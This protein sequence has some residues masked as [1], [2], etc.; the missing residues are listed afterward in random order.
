MNRTGSLQT[1]RVA[2]TLVLTMSLVMASPLTRAQDEETGTGGGS[3]TGE[4]LQSAEE[5]LPQLPVLGPSGEVVFPAGPS[6]GNG[7][8]TSRSDP[9]YDALS[10][11]R[12]AR[13]AG[14][15]EQAA[16]HFQDAMIRAVPGSAVYREAEEELNFRLPLTRVERLIANQEWREVDESLGRLLTRHE[17]DDHKS[18]YLLRLISQLQERVPDD[19]EAGD[20]RPPGRAVTESIE[21]TLE[22]FRADTGRYPRGYDEL[23]EVLPADQDPLLEYDIVDYV[24]RG[25]AYGLTL[26]NKDDPENVIQVQ[27]TGLMR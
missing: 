11:G 7:N 15:L 5:S 13:E 4:E 8:T 17:G 27:K 3:A 14:E 16:S 22:R 1:P 10:R 9:G 23:N 6:S 18:L 20:G 19:L 25:D 26:R 12:K 2:A 21:Q 24:N